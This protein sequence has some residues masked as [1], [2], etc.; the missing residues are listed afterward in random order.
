MGSSVAIEQLGECAS[1]VRARIEDTLPAQS[2]EDGHVSAARLIRRFALH[3]HFRLETF[4]ISE[5]RSDSERA[6]FALEA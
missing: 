3:H 5:D 2:A 4:E 1:L 6:P